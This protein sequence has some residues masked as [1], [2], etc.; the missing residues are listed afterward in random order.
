V[1]VHASLVLGLAE[2][3][4]DNEDGLAIIIVTNNRFITE[5]ATNI[6]L[7]RKFYYSHNQRIVNDEACINR[8]V[9]VAF[10]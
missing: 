3:N 5:G 2:T 9:V 1:V 10:E 8:T 7:L 6:I 4:N